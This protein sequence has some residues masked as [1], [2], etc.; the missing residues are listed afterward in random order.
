MVISHFGSSA[1]AA[2]P[3]SE[4]ARF[5]SPSR[6]RFG[7]HFSFLLVEVCVLVDGIPNLPDPGER[8]WRLA[9]AV[10]DHL[11]H[12][13]HDTL[14]PLRRLPCSPAPHITKPSGGAY[15]GVKSDAAS[16]L[17]ERRRVTVRRL[18][19]SILEVFSTYFCHGGS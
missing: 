12:R 19:G 1:R 18:G 13:L 3:E 8:L 11:S 4:L 7:S 9:G 10:R 5:L 6:A 17:P 16:I 2:L 14:G 15:S